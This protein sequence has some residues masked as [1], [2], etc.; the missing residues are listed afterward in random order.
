VKHFSEKQLGNW[1]MLG[2]KSEIIDNKGSGRFTLKVKDKD[3]VS[4]RSFTTNAI[5]VDII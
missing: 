5:V 3:F 1:V 4:I 2:A